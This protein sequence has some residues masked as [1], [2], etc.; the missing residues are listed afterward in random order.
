[1]STFLCNEC[2]KKRR[3]R[4]SKPTAR[5]ILNSQFGLDLNLFSCMPGDKQV[6][7]LALHCLTAAVSLFPTTVLNH[8]T[9]DLFKADKSFNFA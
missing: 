2:E 6:V 1:V 4:N 3:E 7:R 5:Q 8:P 9:V